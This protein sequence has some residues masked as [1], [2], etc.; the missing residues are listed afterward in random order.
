MFETFSSLV[1]FNVFFIGRLFH[2]YLPVTKLMVALSIGLL[3]IIDTCFVWILSAF[4]VFSVV[5]LLFPS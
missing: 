4:Q 5:L 1:Y 3:F 2:L